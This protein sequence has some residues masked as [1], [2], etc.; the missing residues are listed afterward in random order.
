MHEFL[1]MYDE[2]E[3][4]QLRGEIEFYQDKIYQIENMLIMIITKEREQRNDGI[5]N[6]LCEI[7]DFLNY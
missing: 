6:E 2:D 1:L 5:A 3:T 7:K 4:A